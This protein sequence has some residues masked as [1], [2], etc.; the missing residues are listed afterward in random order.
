LKDEEAMDW[1][2]RISTFSLDKGNKL[3]ECHGCLPKEG[4]L[5][6]YG[7]RKKEEEEV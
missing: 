6:G 1:C 2:K 3:K 5:L 7:R 4:G